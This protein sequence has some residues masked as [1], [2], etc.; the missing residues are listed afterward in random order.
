MAAI[1]PAAIPTPKPR[2]TKVIAKAMGVTKPIPNPYKVLIKTYN[3]MS[4]A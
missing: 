4:Q 1:E 2:R 3:I